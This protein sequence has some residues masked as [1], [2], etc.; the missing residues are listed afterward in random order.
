VMYEMF[1]GKVPFEADS[2]MGVLTKHMYMA[3]APPSELSP[4]LKSLGALEEVILRC[5]QKRP[6]ARYDNLAA[7][8]LELDERLPLG[9][10]SGGRSV[11]QAS[12]LADQLELPSSDER[13][14]PRPAFRYWPALV[15]ALAFVAGVAVVIA[16]RRGS[17]PPL[18]VAPP[19]SSAAARAA[20]APLPS[21]AAP[22]PGPHAAASE[23]STSPGLPSARAEAPARKP[24][25]AGQRPAAAPAPKGTTTRGKR[26]LGGGEIIDPWA[27]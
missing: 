6:Q 7:L 10:R 3:P 5:L 12:L 13:R 9:S 21:A 18:E 16:L 17:R 11:A 4:E 1:T 27:H 2:Y 14:R 23:P 20:S 25:P 26:R 24:A 8:L 22:S 15:I 19:P